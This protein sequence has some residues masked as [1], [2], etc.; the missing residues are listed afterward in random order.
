[1]AI[2]SSSSANIPDSGSRDTI[3][4]LRDA[5]GL[6]D[7]GYTS[8]TDCAQFTGATMTTRSTFSLTLLAMAVLASPVNADEDTQRLIAAMMGDTPVVEDLRELTDTIGGRPTGSAA[9]REA[10]AWAARKFRTAEVAVT[11][12][13]FVM[14]F[15]WRENAVTASIGGDT[16][17]EPRV[18]SRPFSA[19]ANALQ[20]P[21]IDAGA[22]TEA[23]FER[24]GDDARGAWALINTPV[25]D[26]DIG[27]GGLFGLYADA[28]VAETNANAAGVAGVVF[29]SPY[30]KNLV[31]R[32]FSSQHIGNEVPVLTMEREHAKRTARLL[33]SGQQL[34]M[35][36]T[37]DV[38]TGG[39]F[40]STN[41]IGE[42]RGSSRPDE[43][44]IFGAHLDSHDL[45]TGALDNGVNVVMLINVA[46]QIVRLGL[47]PERTIRFA[48]WNGEE[49]GLNG[50]WSYTDQHEGELDQH[51]VAASFDIGSG[52]TTGFFTGGRP[53][54]V[55]LVDKYLEPVAGLGPFQQ[56][57][58]PLVGTDN[59]DF[60]MEGVPNI[61]AAQSDANYASNYHAESD[62]FDKV[63]LNQMR[64][65]SAIAAAVIWGFANDT[66]RLPRQTAEE[67][68]EL[69]ANS[70]LEQQMK[71]FAVWEYWV[72]RTRGRHASPAIMAAPVPVSDPKSAPQP[73][74]ESQVQPVGIGAEQ[75]IARNQT[76]EDIE[77]ALQHESGLRVASYEIVPYE[78]LLIT[79]ENGQVWRQIKGDTQKIR[80][81]LKRN[82]TVDIRESKISG[83]TLR[84]NE[85]RRV[86]RVERIQ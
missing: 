38:E 83:Y 56:V 60:M 63:D 62:T 61:I 31:F 27:L 26:D 18:I 24:L 81:D 74:T 1:L 48:L 71:N 16:A 53:G 8:R 39:Q 80:V 59:F 52:R 7:H 70:D 72:N 30:P 68:G 73:Q 86:I 15:Q 82:Q 41:V 85:M 46:R 44:V 43:I 10:V 5:A 50:S 64:L 76:S 36:A 58:I 78:R 4:R 51:V 25:L 14:P 28:L 69:V 49:Q 84:L 65:N 22:G 11:N 37:V 3:S 66:E 2:N 20:A 57:D 33:Q 40:T 32:Q 79:L 34:S 35:T 42:I 21:L 29:M 47:E 19:A 13:D 75:V 54:L 9:N 12:E 23:D 45:G 55:P 77:D 6:F 17:F 67:V